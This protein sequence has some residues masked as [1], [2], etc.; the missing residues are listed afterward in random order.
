MSLD[1]YRKKRDPSRTPEP[2]AG[3][4]KGGGTQP[5]FVVQ[6]HDARRLHYDLRLEMEG[7]L[8]SWALPKG[9]PLEPGEKYLAVHVED[10]PMEYADF[11]G[12]IPKGQYGAGTMEI[13]DRGRVHGVS[14]RQPF[15]QHQGVVGV[16]VQIG[17]VP[18]DRVQGRRQGAIAALVRVQL[19]EQLG[20]TERPDRAIGIGQG[21]VGM[22]PRECRPRIW[23]EGCYAALISS[24]ICE[25]SLVAL[26]PRNFSNSTVCKAASSYLRLGLFTIAG[27]M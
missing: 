12:V 19:G 16:T 7:T 8:A 25:R 24:Q 14:Q 15:G 23:H 22:Q 6:R 17:E 20:R 27:L 9:L 4:R 26:A 2:P 21:L 1:E 5:V 10:H 13:W 3:K 11:S 18:F